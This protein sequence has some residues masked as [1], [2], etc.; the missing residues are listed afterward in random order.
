MPA[1]PA[2][3]PMDPIAMRILIAE[4]WDPAEYPKGTG[5]AIR[6]EPIWIKDGRHPITCPDFLRDL[7]IMALVESTM[8]PDELKTFPHALSVVLGLPSDWYRK[9]KYLP[10]VIRA[11]AIQ[12]AQAFLMVKGLWPQ[13]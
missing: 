4:T 9:V 3:V 10:L 2:P 6:G 1:K 5:R 11:D 8:S 13:A 7:N 12:R